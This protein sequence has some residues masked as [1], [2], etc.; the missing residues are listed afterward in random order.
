MYRCIIYYC[1]TQCWRSSAGQAASLVGGR[2]LWTTLCL[3]LIRHPCC[4]FL[5]GIFWLLCFH[6]CE[7][8]CV[9]NSLSPGYWHLGPLLGILLKWSVILAIPIWLC[10]SAVFNTISTISKRGW[11]NIFLWSG[12]KT[13]VSQGVN[14]PLVDLTSLEDK[15]LGEVSI[16]SCY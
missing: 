2:G 12:L 7:W 6:A 15:S 4:C 14:N 11:C 8:V 16:I 10:I 13:L 1:K 9:R 3:K 5:T